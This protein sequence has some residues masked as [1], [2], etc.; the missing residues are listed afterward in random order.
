MS[1]RV[2][3]KAIEFDGE[4]GVK[5]G[6]LVQDQDTLTFTD[7]TLTEAGADKPFSI[8]FW[9]NI[10]KDRTEPGGFVAGKI[11]FDGIPDGGGIEN[12]GTE[13][14]VQVHPDASNSAF[15]IGMFLYDARRSRSAHQL[16]AGLNDTVTHIQ[17]K[18]WHHFT[19][20]YNA[21]PVFPD[22]LTF[23]DTGI[24][25]FIDGAS[26]ALNTEQRTGVSVDTDGDNIPDDPTKYTN[27]ANTKADFSIG[28]FTEAFDEGADET[29]GDPQAA[30]RVFRGKLADICI[31]NKAISAAEV[32]EIYN[33]GKVK[34]M[35][36]F[37]AYESIVSWWKM[38]DDLDHAGTDGIKDYVG[39]NH[40]TVK[41]PNTTTIVT[42]PALPTDRIGNSGV[43]VPSSWGRTRGPKN[44]A[45]DHQVYIHGGLSGDMPTAD[46]SSSTDGYHTEAQ[47]FLHLY[48]KAAS[49]T[50][51]VTAWGYSYA[52]GQWSELIDANG[53][54]IKLEV[55]GQAVDTYRVFEIAGVDKVYFKQSGTALAA[56]D[57]FAAAAST[58]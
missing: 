26:V 2:N 28:Q 47:R 51:A 41:F 54:P 39:T 18:T 3:L 32:S 22:N 31:F 12:R 36:K 33:G 58:F 9:M 35:T 57:L 15:R 38:G 48:W 10:D 1:K 20:T 30:G 8:S 19:F 45:G 43:M 21:N 29:A 42:D 11:N 4:A 46:P 5:S 50:A 37:S 56:T 25:L 23:T 34:D 17:S 14:F 55:A 40:G 53:T 52:S 44:V 13:W 16:R 24:R 27:M 7:G 6:I 49:T